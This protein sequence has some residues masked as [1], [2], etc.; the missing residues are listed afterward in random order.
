MFA[1]QTEVPSISTDTRAPEA[2]RNG[3]LNACSYERL[4]AAV[5]AI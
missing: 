5:A 2:P 1:W 4:P 3:V